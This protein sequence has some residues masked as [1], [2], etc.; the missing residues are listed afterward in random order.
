MLYFY[1]C[2]ITAPDQQTL[3]LFKNFLIVLKDIN[4]S[5]E[6]DLKAT[7]SLYNLLMNSPFSLLSIFYSRICVW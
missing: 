6:S 4:I 7:V 3:C 1:S 5:K 2:V